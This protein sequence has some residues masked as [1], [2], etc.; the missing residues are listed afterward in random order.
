M[1]AGH[2]SIPVEWLFT[3]NKGGTAGFSSFGMGALF[4]WK[5]NK[6]IVE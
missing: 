3:A 2:A 1:H 6:K 5:K 4:V